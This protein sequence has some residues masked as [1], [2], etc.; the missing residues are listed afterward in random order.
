M[1]LQLYLDIL[2]RRSPILVIVTAI[3]LIVVIVQSLIIT[4]VYKARATIRV[5]QDPGILDYVRRSDYSD[6]QLRT[7][8]Y[9]LSSD[10]ILEKVLASLGSRASLLSVSRLRNKLTVERVPLTELIA[11]TVE[12]GDP[13]LARDI[14]NAFATALIQ[15]AKDFYLGG[16]QDT[17]QLLTKELIEIETS[18]KAEREQLYKLLAAGIES[19]DVDAIKTKISN[20]ETSQSLRWQQLESARLSQNLQV[21]SITL[22]Q[23]A[24]LPETPANALRLSDIGLAIGLGLLGGIGLALVLEN[25]DT[26]VRSPQQL[27]HITSLPNLGVVPRGVLSANGA[28]HSDAKREAALAEAYRL[29][30]VNLGKLGQLSRLKTILITSAGPSEGKTTVATNLARTAAEHARTVFLV[31]GDMR[32]PRQGKDP[33]LSNGHIG[34]SNLLAEPSSLDQAIQPTEQPTLFMIEGGP[35]PSNPALLLA[36]PMMDRVLSFLGGQGHLTIIDAPP[37]L[38]MTDVSIL[39]TKVDGVILVAYQNLSDQKQI[40]EALKQ[41]QSIQANIIGSI[42]IQRGRRSQYY[43]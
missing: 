28:E 1:E 8:E 26:N 4:P 10:P 38:G 16:Q 15:Y 20:L 37:V 5:S 35:V 40:S 19:P 33:S 42:F 27:E 34:L 2:K 32:H 36:S 43:V 29:V 9:I 17:N 21:D 13:A 22:A 24:S 3:A 41:L 12:N 39:A 31:K 23:P 18:L 30:N 7:Y 6:N 11:I 25:L 14:A